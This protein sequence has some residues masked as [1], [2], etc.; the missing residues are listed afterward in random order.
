M[1]IYFA[2]VT[3]VYVELLNKV[4]KEL[5]TPVHVLYSYGMSK[6]DV[7]WVYDINP[8]ISILI[9][10]GAWTVFKQNKIIDVNDYCKWL[11]KQ[12]VEGYFNLDV[13][14][15]HI[16]TRKNQDYME[17]LGYK[18]IPVYHVGEDYS[19][20]D[21]MCDRYDY[22][23]IGGIAHKRGRMR[24]KYLS[25]LLKRNGS[26]RLH[27]LGVAQRELLERFK[28][29]IYSVDTTSPQVTQSKGS[30][31]YNGKR[32][33]IFSNRVGYRRFGGKDELV[34]LRLNF[35]EWWKLQK[36]G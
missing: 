20:F 11:D 30:V 7:S 32:Q 18:P 16:Q 35:Y 15:D 21:D 24:E 1:K 13:I 14:G 23:G 9:D 36:Y 2:E 22:V 29:Q 26:T 8:D 34:I 17:S 28:D 5:D 33:K 12:D 31:M 25:E 10:S 4:L 27:V 6:R 19:I 3:D